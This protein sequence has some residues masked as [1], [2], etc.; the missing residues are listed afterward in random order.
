MKLWW[1]KLRVC[2]W[3]W[4]HGRFW[5]W[6]HISHAEWA[7]TYQAYDGNAQTAALEGWFCDY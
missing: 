4:R 7:E 2:L 6:A 1:F 5:A 3:C